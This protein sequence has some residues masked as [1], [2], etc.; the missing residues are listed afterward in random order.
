[1]TGRKVGKLNRYVFPSMANLIAFFESISNSPELQEDFED[2]LEELLMGWNKND[3]S[4]TTA[5]ARFV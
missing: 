4:K 5:F 1:M 3:K 2:E